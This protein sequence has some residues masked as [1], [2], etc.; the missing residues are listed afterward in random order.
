[1]PI[2]YPIVVACQEMVEI[3]G[4]FRIIEWLGN[5]LQ[6]NLA[7]AAIYNRLVIHFPLYQM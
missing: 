6:V 2:Q 3:T 5:K 4:A 7:H 1:M